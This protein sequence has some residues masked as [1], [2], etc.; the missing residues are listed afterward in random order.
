MSHH[1]VFP[2]S[3]VIVNYNAGVLLNAC[4][5]SCLNEARQIIVVD[6]GSCD[7]SIDEIKRVFHNTNKIQIIENNK[8]LGFAVACNIGLHVATEPMVLFLNPDCKLL[9]GALQKM[10]VAL[11]SDVRI[12]MVGGLLIN[13]KGMEERGCRRAV[14]TPWRSFVRVFGLYRYSNRWPRLFYDFNLHHQ[15]LPSNAIEMEAISGA[16]MLTKLKAVEDVGLWDE[17]YFLHCEDLDWCMRYR[18]QGWKILFEPNAQIIHQQ[19]ACSKSRPI[20]VEWHKHKGMMRFYRKFFYH[21]YP[22]GLMGAVSAGVWFRFIAIASWKYL[23]RLKFSLR[24]YQ[25]V[26]KF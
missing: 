2:V 6:N 25:K 21:Q 11:N 7:D 18:K 17:G 14:P 23:K 3:I 20:F 9:D 5:N 8:N 19:G 4:V 12:G 24:G 26:R 10:V 16:C 1:P 13:E 22:L 15:P